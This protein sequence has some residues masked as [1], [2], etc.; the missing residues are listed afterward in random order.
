MPLRMQSILESSAKCNR[1]SF[2]G[3]TG[4]ESFSRARPHRP[5]YV[6]SDSRALIKPLYQRSACTKS[7]TRIRWSLLSR[8]FDV[9]DSAGGIG[10]RKAV[11]TQPS[12]MDLDR[13]PQSALRFFD[14]RPSR[15]AAGQIGNVCRVVR[16]CL[17]HNNRVTLH[18]RL[19]ISGQPVSRCY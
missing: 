12:D 6:E 4:N 18:G 15:Y 19:A 8:D 17:L 9:I 14:S 16:L 7:P 11:L 5:A 3:E 10:Y 13:L 2:D 1:A